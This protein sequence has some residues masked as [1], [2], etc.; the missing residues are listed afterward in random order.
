M[1]YLILIT[2]IFYMLSTAGYIAY[3]FAQKDYLQRSAYYLLAVGFLLHTAAMAYGFVQSGHIPVG[4]LFETLSMAAWTVAGVF[5]VL[6]YK[7]KLKVL[8]IYAAPLVTLVMATAS[9]L[10]REPVQVTNIYKSFWLVIHVIAIFIGEASF[11]LACGVG[12]LYLIQEHSI[13]TKQRGF[14]FRRLPSLEL[15][16]ATGYGCIVAGFAMLSLGLIAGFV[17]AKSVWGKFWSWDPKEVWA[18]ITWLLYAA[19]LHQRLTV[20]WRG[21]RAAIMAII[22]FAAVLFTFL[23]VNFLLQGHH[24]EFTRW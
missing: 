24:G 16:D 22:G 10:P 7:F 23:G 6:Q 12:L 1:D 18:G 13:K 3:L 9:Q 15:L 5:L 4:N 20:G 14:F 21:R 2:I 17:Y 11:A 8:G 19:L